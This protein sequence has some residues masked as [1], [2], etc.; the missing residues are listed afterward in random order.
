MIGAINAYQATSAL[1]YA[2]HVMASRETFS[3]PES[4]LRNHPVTETQGA[5]ALTA[6]NPARDPAEDAVQLSQMYPQLLVGSVYT[7]APASA[8]MPVEEEPVGVTD[9][10]DRDDSEA[11]MGELLF[12]GNGKTGR[13]GTV[14]EEAEKAAGGSAADLAGEV[15][16]LAA[17]NSD[18]SEGGDTTETGQNDQAGSSAK[19]GKA[20]NNRNTD[21]AADGSELSE[22][23]QQEVNRLKARDLEVKAHE[24]A[25][26]SVGGAYAGSISYEYDQGPDG[27][28]YAVGG[29]VNIDVSPEKTP[30]ATIAKMQQVK[31][32]AN[33]P[34]NPSG[35]DRAVAAEAA[36]TEVKAR[37]EMAE[38]NSSNS[39]KSKGE[40][41][42]TEGTAALNGAEAAAGSGTNPAEPNPNNRNDNEKR[43]DWLDEVN[44]G[45]KTKSLSA[46]GYINRF[47]SPY[48]GGSTRAPSMSMSSRLVDVVA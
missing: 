11:A 14:G 21:K 42:G 6:S 44:A 25:H 26:K 43:A 34:A 7:A 1:D 37:Q 36:A 8:V 39:S 23:E 22:E 30:E 29:E 47:A 2:R 5:Q 48:E 33:A 3:V 19:K 28:R 38:A 46:N 45:G 20:D 31:A 24:Q 4:Q 16:A 9:N 27:E 40:G 12:G 41:E 32:A 17:D 35:Q 18:D 15:L 10:Q 13:D